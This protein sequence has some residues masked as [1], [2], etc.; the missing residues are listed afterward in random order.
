M[1]NIWIFL[2]LFSGVVIASCGS[3]EKAGV[4]SLKV[5]VV[6]EDS[7]EYQLIVSDSKFEAF[8]AMQPSSEFYSQAYYEGWNQQYVI[9]WNIRHSNPIRYGG[10]YETEIHYDLFT[11]YGMD[12]NYRL[13]NYFRFIEKEYGIQLI[14]RAR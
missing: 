14:N 12:L 4:S 3:T 8:L 5:K 7:L 11:D 1:K 9:E 13:Y 6:A 10:F 2:I